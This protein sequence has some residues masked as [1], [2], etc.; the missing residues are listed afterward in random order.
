[1]ILKN[2]IIVAVSAIAVLGI[3]G[4]AQAFPYIHSPYV[5]KGEGIVELK[6]KYAADDDTDDS[7]STELEAGYGITDFWLPKIG[8]EFEDEGGDEDAEFTKFIFENKFQLAPKETL[9]LDPALLV[10]YARSLNGGQDEIEAALVLAKEVGKFTNK[11][12]IGVAREFGDG[13]DPETSYA[14]SYGLYYDYSDNFE[15]GAEW[16]SNFGD[17]SDNFDDQDHS[18]GPI[19]EFELTEGT[20]IEAGALFGVSDAAADFTFKTVF[21][22]EF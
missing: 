9:F 15:F 14:F 11:S 6:S 13:H 7:W 1:M 2:K 4:Q 20:E 5:E 22:F 19:A 3:G 8:V 21:E 16:F 17:F 18:V 10:E 12:E